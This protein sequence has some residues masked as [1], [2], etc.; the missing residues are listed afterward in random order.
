MVYVDPLFNHG[1]T[2]VPKCFRNVQSCHLF[3]DSESELHAFA[4]RI[5]MKRHWFQNHPR[6]KHYDLTPY[7][8]EKALQAGAVE[9]NDHVRRVPLKK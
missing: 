3:A 1:R 6:L 5:G 4:K 8:R 7:M 2:N 9:V